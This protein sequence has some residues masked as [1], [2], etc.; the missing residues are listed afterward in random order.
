VESEPTMS[1]RE[2]SRR[3][4]A[5]LDWRGAN[6]NLQDMACRV[7]LLELERR[8]IVKLPAPRPTPNFVHARKNASRKSPLPVAKIGCSLQA[9]GP[10]EV[11][12]VS[13]RYSKDSATW[14]A[15]M[16]EWHYLGAGPLCGAQL[17]YLI[18]SAQHGVLGGL[19]FSSATKRLKKRDDWIGWSEAGRRANL[20]RVVCNSRFLIAPG[21]QVPNL[22]SHVLRRSI[23]R[24]AHDWRE[25]YGFAPV[26]LETFVD[27]HFEGTCYRAANWQHLGQTAGRSEGFKNGKKPTG[28]KKIF[29]YRLRRDARKLL[30]EK[31]VP[32]L[33][34]KGRGKD[35]ENWAEQEFGGGQLFDG[36]LRRRLVAVAE[37]FF[38]QPGRVVPQACGGSVAKTK[39]TYRLLSNERVDMQML[40][41][42]HVEATV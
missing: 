7:A 34:L 24:L 13:S 36:R 25:R 2:L 11:V 1:R 26:L 38:A 5:W 8:G 29:V 23:E 42:G 32:S 4:C 39:A 10:V 12:P 27:G 14:K 16:A 18:R 31:P 35:C 28:R 19:A 3:V 30:C 20:H 17:R 9:L 40:L 41:Q 15:M 33:K 6:G 22:A 21:V 37:D